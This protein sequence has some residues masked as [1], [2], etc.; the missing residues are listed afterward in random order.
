MVLEIELAKKSFQLHGVNISGQVVII[1]KLI[2][3]KLSQFMAQLPRF[4]VGIEACGVRTT[5][6]VSLSVL[7]KPKLDRIA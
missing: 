2:R 6:C 1:K 7:R 5:G 3:N 4:I